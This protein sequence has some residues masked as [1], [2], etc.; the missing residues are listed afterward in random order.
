MEDGIIELWGEPF[1]VL[2]DKPNS[3]LHANLGNMYFWNISES[4][5]TKN[6]TLIAAS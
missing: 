6:K 4:K 3:T 5:K 2:E 1:V